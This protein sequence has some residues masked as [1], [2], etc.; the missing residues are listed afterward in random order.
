MGVKKLSF[1]QID[2]ITTMSDE[3]KQ[4]FRKLLS[5]KEEENGLKVLTLLKKLF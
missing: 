3:E 4:L 1:D 2:F 5:G